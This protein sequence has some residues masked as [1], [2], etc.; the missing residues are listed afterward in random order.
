MP[1]ETIQSTKS[2]IQ[3]SV[4]QDINATGEVLKSQV[5]TTLMEMF[6]GNLERSDLEKLKVRVDSTIDGQTNNLID[7]IIKTT[8]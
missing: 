8:T 6:S 4:C 2:K 1:R 3:R 7:R 5:F